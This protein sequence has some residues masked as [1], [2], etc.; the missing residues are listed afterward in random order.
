MKKILVRLF[1]LMVTSQV[2]W[3]GQH[4]WSGAY[5]GLN[6]GLGTGQNTWVQGV[7]GNATGPGTFSGFDGGVT[8]GTDWQSN[9]LVFGALLDGNFGNLEA[10][11]ADSPG[12]NCTAPGCHTQVN[13]LSTARVKFGVPVTDQFL[14]YATGG[15]AL[16][17]VHLF[18]PAS[19]GTEVTGVRVGWTVGLGAETAL[20][21]HL[22][23]KTEALYVNLG[24]QDEPN[25]CGGNCYSDVSFEEV[26]VGLN[27]KF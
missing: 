2:A 26:R 18:A 21:N 8:L 22:S 5:I 27:Y 7:T 19:P 13:W 15:A 1:A 12:F 17:G 11:D 4:D 10:N 23:V 25:V 24:R 9:N 16:G 6:A 14:V 20:S 3:A